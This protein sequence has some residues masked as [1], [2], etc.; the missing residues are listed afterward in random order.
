MIIALGLPVERVTMMLSIFV[1]AAQV[2]TIGM[3]GAMIAARCGSCTA[4]RL[5]D[6]SAPSALPLAGLIALVATTGS[7]YMQF[8]ANFT[9]CELCWFQRIA[10]Y[11]LVIVLGVGI[12]RREA[13]AWIYA[14]PIAG[15]GSTISAY[16]YQLERFPTQRTL[17]CEITNPCTTIWFERFGYITI[18]MM[19]LTAFLCISALLMVAR[20]SERFTTRLEHHG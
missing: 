16:H 10:M 17:S 7:L 14:L 11:P 15:A 19:A 12:W 18:S 9:P 20:R 8:G 2:A 1:V 6:R 3:V 13:A 4:A 5:L